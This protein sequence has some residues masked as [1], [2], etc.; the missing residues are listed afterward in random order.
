MIDTSFN[1]YSDANGGD[2]DATSPTLHGY[3]KLLS[4]KSLPSG[5]EEKVRGLF[6]YFRSIFASVHQ[7][8]GLN[9][10][11]R[12]SLDLMQI[13]HRRPDF[14]HGPTIAKLSNGIAG[15][16]DPMIGIASKK[17]LWFNINRF[18]D[19]GSQPFAHKHRHL[20]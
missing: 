12:E 13:H 17:I 10:M 5:G 19:H 1:M 18:S 3:H 11:M 14:P 7:D 20:L 8:L 9:G 4:S 6:L 15:S 2:P 16:N